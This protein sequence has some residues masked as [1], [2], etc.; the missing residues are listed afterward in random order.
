MIN[1]KGYQ[2]YSKRRGHPLHVKRAKHILVK[3]YVH[4]L[5]E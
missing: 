3:S 4:L 2:K 1:L 5:A